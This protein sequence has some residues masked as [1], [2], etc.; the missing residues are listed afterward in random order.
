MTLQNRVFP[1]GDIVTHP[2]RG[3]FMGNRGILHDENRTLGRRRWT[4]HAWVTCLLDFK[5]RRR[6]LMTPGRYTELFFLDEATALAAGHRPCGECRRQ[7]YRR[8]RA[9]WDAAHG[10]TH[11]IGALDRILHRDRVTRQ[12]RQIRHSAEY[13]KLPDG[14][15]VLCDGAPHLVW[16][17]RLLRYS[18]AGYIAALPRPATGDALVLTPASTLAVMRQGYR[19]A[20][21][22]SAH[23]GTTS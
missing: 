14:A 4:H 8:F 19:P 21:H 22:T 6:T 12:R 2:A 3:R 7:D 17:D 5:G 1:T 20:L 18:P 23:G 9:F 10:T 15:F 16:Q 11:K 13:A